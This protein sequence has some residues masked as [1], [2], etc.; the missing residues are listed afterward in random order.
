M[1]HCA[2]GG[3]VKIGN[4]VILAGQVGIADHIEIGDNVIVAAQ[5]GV[6]KYIPPHMVVWGTPAR[7]IK[8]TKKSAILVN[9]L[10]EIYKRLKDLEKKIGTK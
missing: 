10:P 7:P 4:N 9:K 6:M 5:A 1:A 2:I 8:D 3:S